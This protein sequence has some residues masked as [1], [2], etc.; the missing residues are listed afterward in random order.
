MVGDP[1]NNR[2]ILINSLDSPFVVT[3][4]LVSLGSEDN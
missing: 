1:I 3:T 2:V 4:A